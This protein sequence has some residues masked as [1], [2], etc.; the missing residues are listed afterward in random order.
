MEKTDIKKVLI[1][2]HGKTE[3]NY[4]KRYI[5]SR[6]DISLSEEGINAVS[7][8]ADNIRKLAEKYIF[9]VSSPMQRAVQTAEIL[10]PGEKL[11]TVEGLKEIDFGD[12][13][14]KNYEVMFVT[15]KN[16]YD[17][18]KDL[19][20][21][22][23]VFVLPYIDNQAK[24]LKSVDLMVTRC[25]ASTLSE[26]IAL[27]IPSILIPSPYVANNHQYKNAM[28][29]CNKNAAILLEEKDLVGN[30]LADLIDK[31]INDSAKLSEMKKNLESLYIPNSAD[32]IYNILKDLVDENERKVN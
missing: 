14:G 10:F 8:K 28:D 18:V 24:I 1:L 26:M 15:G 27:D 30:N 11:L 29:L 7:E 32:R 13:E 2:R 6:T 9:L 16:V 12:F 20:F 3:A 31:T 22:Y 19:S 5:G 25:G 17:M 4:E 23:N 21:P